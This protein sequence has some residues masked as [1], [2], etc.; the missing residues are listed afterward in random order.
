MRKKITV[1]LFMCCC[2]GIVSVAQDLRSVDSL[3]KIISAEKQDTT[4]SNSLLQ[5][6]KQYSDKDNKTAKQFALR[7]LSLAQKLSFKR[8]IANAAN[9]LGNL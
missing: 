5:L 3:K 8:G 4:V 2:T 9:T 7:S 6:A 1:F